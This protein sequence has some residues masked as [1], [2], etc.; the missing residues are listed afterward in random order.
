MSGRSGKQCRE[1][2]RNHLSPGIRKDAFTTEED[3]IILRMVKDVGTKW[4]LMAK[5]LPG[6]TD[7]AIK[8]RYNSSLSRILAKRAEAKMAAD[9]DWDGPADRGSRGSPKK[10]KH[11]E[12]P[13]LS[14]ALDDDAI[15]MESPKSVISR[16]S[17]S[18]PQRRRVMSTHSDGD[19]VTD[20]ESSPHLSH[21]TV[22]ASPVSEVSD[23]DDDEMPCKR[24]ALI[25]PEKATVGSRL[26]D[27][28]CDPDEIEAMVLSAA[29][30][31]SGFKA[32]ACGK[33]HCEV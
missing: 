2:W 20:D 28:L 30:V 31:L 23:D 1:R 6:R 12:T 5:A 27:L 7:N 10:R 18:R 25:I 11:A 24:V 26:S 14:A 19:D 8:N 3:R 16:R 13:D 29:Q 15:V 4:S 21:R 32:E 9:D 22:T 33:S 17:S